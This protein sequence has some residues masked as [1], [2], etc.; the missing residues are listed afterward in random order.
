MQN[1][2]NIKVGDIIFVKVSVVN[3]EKDGTLECCHVG[4]EKY[5]PSDDTDTM[6]FDDEDV[7]IT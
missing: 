1:T 4:E 5:Y 7:V 6:F 2:A 3:I